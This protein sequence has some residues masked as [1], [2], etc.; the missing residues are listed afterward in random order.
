MWGLEGDTPV[1]ADYD[2]DGH[3]DVAVFRSSDGTWY[4]RNSSNSFS[5]IQAF[6][7]NGDL[8]VPG[9]YD[10]DGLANIAT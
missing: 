6:G 3:D 4:I 2:G 9:D 7:T 5:K 1:P 10:G 8:P